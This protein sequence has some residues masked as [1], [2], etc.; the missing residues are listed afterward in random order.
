MN[1][2]WMGQSSGTISGLVILNLDLK[3]ESY[4][5]RITLLNAD[6]TKVSLVAQVKIDKNNF[7]PHTGKFSGELF[8][9]LPIKIMS[10]RVG[11][12]EEF[13]DISKDQISEIGEIN[14]CFKGEDINGKLENRQML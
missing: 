5:G 4:E 13:P 1:G 9:F 10:R 6:A 3:D 8:N 11:K 12:W 7:D 2:Q 14:G